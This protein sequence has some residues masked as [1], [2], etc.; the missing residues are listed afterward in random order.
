MR[1]RGV[2]SAAV[3][4]AA[5]ALSGCSQEPPVR[6]ADGGPSPVGAP[7]QVRLRDALLTDRQL[8]PAFRLLTA[9]A[10]PDQHFSDVPIT[11]M[12]CE[13][14]VVE[15][16]TARH[17]RPAEGVSVGLEKPSD[18]WF[19]RES[20]DRYPPGRA[21]AVM[22][23]VH[24][25]AQR[26][27][28]YTATLPVDG[29]PTKNTVSTAGVGGVAAD[30]GLVLRISAL[31]PGDGEPYVTEVALVREGDVILTVHKTV[32]Q[33]PRSS[34]EAVLP[35]AVAAYRAAAGSP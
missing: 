5:L 11:A 14:L 8:P 1:L 31:G 27:A 20:L 13:E 35:A 6:A 24:G 9:S 32:A 21:A 2:V 19:G 16:F 17:D 26:C 3:V 22:A 12:P 15:G 30:D 7:A 4:A 10:T 23:A 25:A 29:S 34:V 18:D 28:S 33:Q